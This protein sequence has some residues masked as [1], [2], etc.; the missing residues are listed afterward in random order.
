MSDLAETYRALGDL[1]HAR[2]LHQKTLTA[3]RRVL[4]NDHPDTVT[5]VSNL[6]AVRRELD[7]Q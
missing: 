3:R 1:Q 6:A 4:G 2:E 7:E 5:S